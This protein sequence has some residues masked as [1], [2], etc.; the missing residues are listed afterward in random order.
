M[1]IPF[2]AVTI[3]E[4]SKKLIEKIMDSERVSSGKYVREF[5]KKFAELTGTREAVAVS[6]GTD[7]IALALAVLSAILVLREGMRLLFRLFLLWQP[8]TQ[9]CRLVLHRCL[10]T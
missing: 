4:K 2:G 8:Q 6:T 10:L 3:T 5:E 7:A 1:K 9:F